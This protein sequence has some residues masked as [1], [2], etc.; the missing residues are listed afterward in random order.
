MIFIHLISVAIVVFSIIF[1]GHLGISGIK[2]DLLFIFIIY[3]S[4]SFG[5]FIGEVYGFWGGLLMDAD[6]SAPLGLYTFSY[7]I[8]GF[9]IGLFGRSVF[10]NNLVTISLLLFVSSVIKGIITMFL[11]YI[12][13]HIK[14]SSSLSVIIIESFYNALLAPLLFFL[15]DR[16]FYREL[17]RQG[18]L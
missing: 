12:F 9:V 10:K 16:L 14:F 17:E 18:V 8:A 2:P 1:E 15:L 4:Y 11:C 13:D 7:V 6:T 3:L 5:S